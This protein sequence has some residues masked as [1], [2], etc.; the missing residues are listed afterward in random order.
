MAYAEWKKSVEGKSLNVDGNNGAQCVDVVKSWSDYILGVS[1]TQTGLHGNA[2][3][4]FANASPVYYEKIINNHNDPG[5]LP[6]QGDIIVF[7]ASPEAG[8]T[9]TYK[10]PYG[11]TAVVESA[12]AD[13]VLTQQ[14]GSTSQSTVKTVH[15]PWKYTR[16]IGWLRPRTKKAVATPVIP[17]PSS[18]TFTIQILPGDWN[19]RTKPTMDSSVVKNTNG[20]P[21]PLHGGQRYGAVIDA[22]GWA[23]ISFIGKTCY[24]GPK[25][26]KRL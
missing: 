17:Q 4:L 10:N 25:T 14:D 3:D 1:F 16:V 9:S 20:T 22:N 7:A 11:H 15:R 24:A 23:K 26:Y 21:A 5:Q 6:V 18:Q 13:L 8:Y 2:K 12:G 19:A